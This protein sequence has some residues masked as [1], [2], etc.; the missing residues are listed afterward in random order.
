MIIRYLRLYLYFLRFSFSK[1]MEF[2]LDFFFR[3]IMDIA[4]YLVH[5]AFFGIIYKHTSMI[6]GWNFD[7]VLI[8]ICGFFVTDSIH[9]T[10]Y[11]NNLWFLPQYINKGDLDYYLVRPV[12]SLFF[13]SVRDFAANSFVNFLVAM[14]LLSWSI[15][16][17]PGDFSITQIII[18]LILLLN[19]SYLY[20]LIHMLFIIPVFWTHSG[21]GFEG[22][23]YAMKQFTERPDQIFNGLLRK[24]LTTVL[25]FLLIAS[26]PAHILFDGIDLKIILFII[27]VTIIMTFFLIW[28]W[29]KAL[30][31]Y[32]S[33]SS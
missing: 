15:Y 32:S 1:A 22:L 10:V 5:I 19:G 25:P 7:Q 31:N 33:A 24:I 27:I 11:A 23:F 4:F 16:R 3:V 6:G 17:Y 18:Y 13:L 21:R 14:G 26:F 2:R 9:M 29:N 8:F 28:F 12:S 20:Y 30:Q